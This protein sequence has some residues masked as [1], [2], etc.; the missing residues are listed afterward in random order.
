MPYCP[1][2][3][4]AIEESHKFCPN[5]G[6]AVN[7]GFQTV[8][9]KVVF[10]RQACAVAK[11]V[12]TR[13]SVDGQVI[14]ELKEEEE[15]QYSLPAGQH[16]IE[17]QLKTSNQVFRKQINV[18]PDPSIWEFPFKIGVSGKAVF[19]GKDQPNH[20]EKMQSK[21]KKSSHR[22]G[23]IFLSLLFLLLIP[24][25]ADPKDGT[26]IPQSTQ[27]IQTEEP[28]ETVGF[29][30]VAGTAGEWEVIVN[31]F[32][33]CESIDAG[34]LHEYRAEDGSKYC[35]VNVTIKNIGTETATF[36]PYLSFDSDSRTRLLWDGYEYK[37][38]EQL[39]AEDNLSNENLNPLVSK[40]GN[41]VFEVP[42]EMTV[43]AEAPVFYVTMGESAFSCE[44]IK[45]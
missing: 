39:A 12:K 29:E 7:S 33:Y 41:I 8:F 32:Y 24:L 16:E 31:D 30:T 40:N 45:K 38:S 22:G 1:Q 13:V 26:S 25:A 36:L 43:S 21:K 34:L 44:L 37:R 11:L 17:I 4:C 18:E 10:K 23:W 19:C 6:T 15:Y 27:P 5:C 28:V 9:G 42:N 3:G 20:T 2:C 35:V 14:V